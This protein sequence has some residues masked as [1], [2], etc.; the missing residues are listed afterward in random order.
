VINEPGTVVE[1]FVLAPPPVT[2]NVN[3]QTGVTEPA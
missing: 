3:D 2:E 1:K